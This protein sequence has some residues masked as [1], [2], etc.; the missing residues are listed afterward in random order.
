MDPNVGTNWAGS[1]RYRAAR[2]ARPRSI[3]ELQETVTAARHIRALGSRHSFTGVADTG[4]VLVET[5]GLP[6]EVTVDRRARRATVS[7]GASYGAVATALHERGWALANLASLPHISGAGAIATGTHGSGDTNGSLAAAVHALELVGP[8]GGLRR[9]QRGD[10]DFPGSVV[11][12][13]C[14]GVVTR[15]TLDLEPSFELSQTVITGAPW[16]AVLADFSRVTGSAYSVSLFTDWTGDEIDQVWLKTREPGELP[17]AL[18]AGA[19][20]RGPVHMLRGGAVEAVTEQLGVPGPWH[21]RLPHFRRAFRPSRGEELQREYGLPRDRLT[22]AVDGL[23]RL[24]PRLAAVL[25]VSEVRTVAADDLWLSGAYGRDAVGVHF[26][27]VRDPDAVYAVLPAVESLLLPMG[28]R[29]HWG[30]CFAT[31]RSDLAAVY[32]RLADFLSLRARVD[33]DRKFLNGFLCQVWG[34]DAG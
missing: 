18:L 20:A 16:D 10:P 11:A 23:R 31:D 12:L 32:P 34:I 1:Y 13:G 6:F 8:D 19:P 17:A 14:L 33:P 7:G 21:E 30:K 25:Q 2:L 22:D 5:S 9:I 29:P 4:G 28:G 24:A 27:W 15:V 3:D 26:T